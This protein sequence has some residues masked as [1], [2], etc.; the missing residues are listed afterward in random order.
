[1]RAVTPARIR[2]AWAVAV[3]VDA[4]QLGLVPVAGPLGAWIATPLDLAAMAVLWAL[5][6]WHWA[7]APSFVFEILPVADLAPTW[8]L[9]TWIVVRKRKAEALSASQER[10]EARPAPSRS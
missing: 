5:L 8:T 9:A 10:A 3:L 4:L 2:A 7:F 6:G 1:M